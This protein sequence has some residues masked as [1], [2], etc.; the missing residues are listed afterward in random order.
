[1]PL[2]AISDKLKQLEQ[3][4]GNSE[5]EDERWKRMIMFPK[6]KILELA[7][8]ISD[9][10]KSRN[11]NLDPGFGP[12]SL[13]HISSLDVETLRTKTTINRIAHIANGIGDIITA[14]RPAINLLIMSSVNAPTAQRLLRNHRTTTSR[15]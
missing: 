4:M 14:P 2:V 5:G 13:V 3:C 8:T 9:A 10:E 12:C 15:R 1:M 6:K 11:E 7:N